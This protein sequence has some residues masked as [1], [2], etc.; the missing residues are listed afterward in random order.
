MTM[1]IMRALRTAMLAMLL[2]MVA[3][4]QTGQGTQADLDDLQAQVSAVS[5][6]LERL[7]DT[8]AAQATRLERDLELIRDDVAYLR[9]RLRRENSLPRNEISAVRDRLAAIERQASGT[10]LRESAPGTRAG[11]VGVGQELDARLQTPLSSQTAEVEDRFEATTLVDLY[12]GNQLLVPAGSVLRGVVSG[13]DRA[14]RTD[15]RGSLTL[16]FD[17]MTVNGRTYR[18]R[19][20]VTQALEGEGIK[21]EVG[22]MTTGAAAGAILGGILGGFRGAMA[23]ILIGGGGAVLA[24]PGTNV[25]LDAGTVLRVRF[26]A[27]VVVGGALAE[28]R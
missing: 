3:L 26:D 16:S 9:V 2:P 1:T 24:T 4:A 17:Q 7:R 25:H 19:A 13:V 11:E 23:G 27:P 20:T 14:T 12:Q 8:D 18:I 5:Q 28:P 22:K 10:S 21:G 15:R 6:R